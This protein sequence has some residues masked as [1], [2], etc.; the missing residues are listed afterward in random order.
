ME[1][2]KENTFADLTSDVA[3]DNNEISYYCACGYIQDPEEFD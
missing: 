2:G 1:C 3:D